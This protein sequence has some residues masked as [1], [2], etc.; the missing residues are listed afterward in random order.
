[1]CVCAC[2]TE[3]LLVRWTTN[4]D[5]TARYWFIGLFDGEGNPTKYW[6]KQGFTAAS[7]DREYM[8]GSPGMDFNTAQGF[9]NPACS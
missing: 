3:A 7:Y 5:H 9:A 1:M 4:L 2:L 8:K 6:V